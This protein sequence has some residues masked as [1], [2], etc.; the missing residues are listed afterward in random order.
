MSL[1]TESGTDALVLERDLLAEMAHQTAEQ[2]A[3]DADEWRRLAHAV[4]RLDPSAL[5]VRE[6]ERELGQAAW[7]M[8][9]LLLR[10][11]HRR[12]EG[13]GRSPDLTL[14]RTLPG[15]AA[16]QHSYERNLPADAVEAKLARRCPELPDGWH[17]A[18]LAFGS[19][20]AALSQVVQGL[21]YLL[22]PT[23]R[24]PLRLDFW[25]DYFETDILLEYL[26]GPTVV[27]RKL[28]ADGLA[29]SWSGP[30]APDV[31]LLEPVRYNWSLD[32]LDLNLLVNG[33]RRAT[34][35]P[36][37]IVLDTTLVSPAWQ[38]AAFLK[39]M[40]S[41]GGAPLVIEV[42]SGLKLDQQ[43]L[44][45]TNLGVV[46]VFQHADTINPELT[47]SRVAQILRLSRGTVGA[48][49]PAAAVAALDAPFLLDEQWTRIHSG[50]LF[51][52]NARLAERMAGSTGGLFSS[53]AHP[54]LS[55]GAW[56]ANAPFVVVELRENTL[57]DHGLL[58]AVIRHEVARR[59]LDAVHGSSFGFRATRYESIVP[60]KVKGTGLFK[61]A[62]GA[63]GGPSLERFGD[64]L[65]EIGAFPS[66]AELHRRYDLP[67]VR[68]A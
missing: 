13:F 2:Q 38:T 16:L 26:S 43:G 23:E 55:A 50:R 18:T 64:L 44:E 35:R 15:G 28:S 17:R 40:T 63:C 60:R 49:L 20:M 12:E 7:R 22:A 24:R 67:R 10:R 34:A 8:R 61:V 5:D 6:A 52:N 51:R 65:T 68:L 4:R 57:E 47:A 32:A 1:A 54:S 62:A 31:L 45:V 48:A 11:G 19:G 58:L 14:S 33:W 30:P 53:V 36:P 37:V 27:P 29:R 42:R 39:A 3:E 9:T 56:R 46:D 59:G 66:T 21:T 41:P 25:G